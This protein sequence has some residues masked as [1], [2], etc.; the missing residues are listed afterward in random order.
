MEV[1]VG[2]FH[3]Q[4]SRKLIMFFLSYSLSNF[5]RDNGKINILA[6]D[7]NNF[8]IKSVLREL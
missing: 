3:V 5:D 8:S 2:S 7:I 6:H 1:E 4:I